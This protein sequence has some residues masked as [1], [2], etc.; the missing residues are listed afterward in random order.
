M[1]KTNQFNIKV[2]RYPGTSSIDIIDHL[3]SSLRKVPD[4]YPYRDRRHK[5]QYQLK[6][7]VKLVR[8][9]SKD[10]ELCFPSIICSTDIKDID[11]N[12]IRSFGKILEATKL[13]L[14]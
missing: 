10:T 6:K 1:N 9:T 7:T 11:R 5:K 12:R 3:K 2:H 4:N 8:E 13:R 14:H